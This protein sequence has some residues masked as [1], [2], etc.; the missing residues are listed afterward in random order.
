MTNREHAQRNNIGDEGVVELVSLLKEL[1]VWSRLE[2][3]EL[4]VRFA[5]VVL[6]HEGGI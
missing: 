1:E 2:G 3:L 5:E 4:N 6:T